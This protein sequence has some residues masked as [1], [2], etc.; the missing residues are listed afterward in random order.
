MT[1]YG[2]GHGGD[3]HY[4]QSAF[5]YPT[6][7]NPQNSASDN[8]SNNTADFGQQAILDQDDSHIMS[9]FFDNPDVNFDFGNMDSHK[10]DGMG[11]FDLTSPTFTSH[12]TSAAHHTPMNNYRTN[13]DGQLFQ[14]GNFAGQFLINNHNRLANPA[15]DEA[16]LYST[17]STLVGLSNSQTQDQ[18]Q[19]LNFGWGFQDNQAFMANDNSMNSGRRSTH[20]AFPAHMQSSGQSI[21][22]LHQAQHMQSR[23]QQIYQPAG[24]RAPHSFNVAD[25]TGAN[26][27]N[28]QRAQSNR[29]RSVYQNRVPKSIVRFGSDDSF[30]PMGFRGAVPSSE[31]E[32]EH[33]LT[34]VPLADQAA[35]SIQQHFQRTLS[36]PTTSYHH[37]GVSG[38]TR[39]AQSP[40]TSPVNTTRGL[41]FASPNSSAQAMAWQRV[42]ELAVEEQEE[43][44]ADYEDQQPRK[45]RKSGITRENEDDAEYV[46][47]SRVQGNVPKRGPKV[48]KAD[49]GAEEDDL[50]SF[51]SPNHNNKT[52]HKRKS[53][54]SRSA[55]TPSSPPDQAASPDAGPSSMS[56]KARNE[57]KARQNLTEDQKRNNHIQSEQK[58]RNVIKQGYSDLNHIVPSLSGGKSGLSKAEV[59]K[60]VVMFLENTVAGNDTM[61]EIL[62]VGN[63][64]ANEF[65]D[66]TGSHVFSLGVNNYQ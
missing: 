26:N 29:P 51:T 5:G 37:T 48:L 59:L 28:Q 10:P 64:N 44:E 19:P 30:S 47:H 32:K 54:M 27:F 39:V 33:N 55:T 66:G 3:H 17:A 15:H 14:H 23:A 42:Q 35:G 16:A 2:G 63:H 53:N 62:S 58:R 49:V 45:R 40:S 24:L 12:P 7:I 46:P 60:E 9:S 36:H 65:D 25:P 4:G 31:Q 8:P 43:E 18:A 13:S 1:Q 6:S 50:D 52:S 20:S 21:Q 11:G 57:A 41:P 38:V 61:T 22:H 34:N 56:K